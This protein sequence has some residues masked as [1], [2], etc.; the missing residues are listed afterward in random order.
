MRDLQIGL[1]TSAGKR[2]FGE[3][4][5]VSLDTDC[6]SLASL[7]ASAFARDKGLDGDTGFLPEFHRSVASQFSF[8]SFVFLRI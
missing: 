1:P 6:S 2:Q 4:T 3:T 5:L 7:G 8:E